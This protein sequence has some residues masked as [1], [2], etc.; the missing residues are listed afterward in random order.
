MTSQP[1]GQRALV[2][3]SSPT[4]P[5]PPPHPEP[6]QPLLR[7]REVH[8]VRDDQRR[9]RRQG[10]VVEEE[11]PLQR[12]QVGRGVPAAQGRRALGRGGGGGASGG[13]RWGPGGARGVHD[14]GQHLRA[15]YVPQELVAEAAVLVRALDQTC[16]PR[17]LGV[18]AA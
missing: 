14:V 6:C 10:G 18:A 2:A 12:A 16:T 1:A 13:G 8:L 3:H 7:A 9:A 5:P 15:L 4:P 17:G 11:L